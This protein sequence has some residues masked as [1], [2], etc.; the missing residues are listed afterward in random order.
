MQYAFIY[1]DLLKIKTR[2]SSWETKSRFSMP[3]MKNYQHV[4]NIYK[5]NTSQYVVNSCLLSFR[6]VL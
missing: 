6:T 1:K 5:K 2:V 3:I 4:E